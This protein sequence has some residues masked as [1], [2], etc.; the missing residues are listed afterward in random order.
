VN[1]P[2]VAEDPTY[3]HVATIDDDGRR[4][5]VTVRIGFDGIDHV[6]RLWF[7]EVGTSEPGLPDRGAIPGRTR[8]DVLI[9]AKKLQ[10]D[11]F[12]KRHRRAVSEKRRFNGLRRVTDEIITKIR[13]MNQVRLSVAAGMLDAEGAQQEI[14]LTV[15]QLHLL[16]EQLAPFAGVED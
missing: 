6:G 5:H 13:Y 7:S 10:P 11:D 3:P 9:A 16:V 2:A 14:D 15:K 8:E 1:R 4:Y 12:V